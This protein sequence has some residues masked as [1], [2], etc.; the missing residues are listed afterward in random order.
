MCVPS[1]CFYVFSENLD[2]QI[3]V[4]VLPCTEGI[5]KLHWYMNL[6]FHSRTVRLHT[7]KVLRPPTD[8]QEN[9]SK[10][11]IKTY[12]KAAPTCF[13]AITNIRERTIRAC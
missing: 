4:K 13:G 6:N 2:L 11:N 10:K 5:F 1:Q 9:C 7:I 3:F 12:T 8:A